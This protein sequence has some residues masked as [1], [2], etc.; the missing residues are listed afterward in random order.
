[1]ADLATGPL[2]LVADDDVNLRKVLSL[3][4]RNAGYSVLEAENGRRALELAKL[5]RPEAVLLDIMMPL[6]D[7]FTV[8]K[9][10]KED[11][12]TKSAAV[13]ICTARNRK[14]D[15][16]AAIKAGAEDYII[17][18]FTK[19]TVLGKVVKALKA[20][21]KSTTSSTKLGTP[22]ERRDSRRKVAG[23]S[24]SWEG[25]SQGGIAP[26]YKTRVY[27]ISLKGLSFEFVRCDICTGYEQGTVHPLCLFAKHAK[28]FQE[29]HTLDFVLS[30]KKDIVI[31][32]QGR[33]A[34]I[35]QW[36]DNP[37]TEKVGVMLTRV[38]PEA[39]KIIEQYLEGTLA[40]V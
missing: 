21:S 36:P 2:V 4:L 28:R 12:E 26:V 33:I 24:L 9:L 15:L 31:E 11:P 35:Y 22:V 29:S 25:Q 39:Y 14:E 32:V 10:I 8:C 17:K 23:W 13:L 30:I 37:G 7:G 3:F 18:P 27:D 5:R 19:E 6:L 16:V 38:S 1:M 34:H 40:L 20:R